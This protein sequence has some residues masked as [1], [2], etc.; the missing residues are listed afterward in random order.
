MSVGALEFQKPVF[1]SLELQLLVTVS[2]LCKDGV[3]SSSLGCFSNPKSSTL[4]MHAMFSFSYTQQLRDGEIGP[5]FLWGLCSTCQ[6]SRCIKRRLLFDKTYLGEMQHP[7]LLTP[8][9]DPV[10]H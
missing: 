3:H 5:V 10:T 2:C 1:D 8:D 4:I 7:C 9:R 6:S